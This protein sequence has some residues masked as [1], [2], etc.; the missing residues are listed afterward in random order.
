MKFR[1]L[2]TIL[3]MG[4]ASASYAQPTNVCSTAVVLIQ[5]S[6]FIQ[7][8]NDIPNDRYMFSFAGAQIDSESVRVEGD[9][10]TCIANLT[11]IDPQKM[12]VL[13]R[14]IV[15]Y[16]VLKNDWEYKVSS[17]ILQHYLERRMN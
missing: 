14:Y 1:M 17:F 10:T 12:A 11:L 6:N 4:L 13:D 8:K 5:L 15:Q 16:N 9:A 2:L 7:A 3:L